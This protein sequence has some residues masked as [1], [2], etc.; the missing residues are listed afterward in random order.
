MRLV[1]C[2]AG[3]ILMAASAAA[4]MAQSAAWR[5]PTDNEIT[6]LIVERNAHRPGQ[7]IVVGVLEP[8]GQRIVAGGTGAGAAVNGDTLFEIASITKV[9]TALILADMVNKGEVALDDP[10]AKYLPPG[11]R[12]PE[13]KGRQITLRD[14]STH[15]SGL[16]R[17]P[18]GMRPMTDADGPFADYTE[19]RL[20]AFLDGYQL[21]RDIDSRWEY[22]NLGV[23]L[24][25]YL[26]GRAAGVDYETLVRQRITGPLGMKNTMIARL[27]ADTAR[28]AAPFNAYMEPTTPWTFD[29][30]S[31]ACG[32]SS[33]AADMLIF[34]RAALDPNSPIAPAMKTALSVRTAS[35]NSEITQALG[36]LVRRGP[37]GAE[38]LLH[39]GETWGYRSILALWPSTGRAVVGLAN[40][41]SD[42]APADLALHILAGAPV[43]PTP[44]LFGGRKAITLPAEALDKVVGH[45]DF[46]PGFSVAVTR[47]GVS[48]YAQREGIAGAPRLPI[49]PERPFAFFWK[50]MEAQI[51]F[52]ADPDGAVTGAEIAQYGQT[53]SGKR[54][55]P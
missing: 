47:D 41:R 1:C 43:Q 49:V 45:Y 42:P 37:D 31:G 16:P 13:R 27:P 24:L 53:Y 19:A 14:L 34:A 36:W 33:T 54:I 40:S 23:G 50:D 20:L 55:Q 8:E 12:M 17:M 5:P 28:L 22:S 30:L 2:V 10:A 26:L 38:I 39:D 3:I 46:G 21:T 32:I 25:G 9:F 44:P 4:A 6:N 11:H 18:D 29:V 7:G 35:G 48:V 52:T 51:R 15:R